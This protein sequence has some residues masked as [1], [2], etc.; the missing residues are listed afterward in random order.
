MRISPPVVSSAAQFLGFAVRRPSASRTAA[1]GEVG[2]LFCARAEHQAL[3]LARVGLLL[4]T[5]DGYGLDLFPVIRY[6]LPR[7]KGIGLLR[8][9]LF[10]HNIGAP[11]VPGGICVFAVFAERFPAFLLLRAGVLPFFSFS[12]AKPTAEPTPAFPLAVP[13]DIVEAVA[14]I[15]LFNI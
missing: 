8:P 14:L 4:G 12:V 11:F 7:F 2:R 3:G 9:F 15:A 10:F 1:P 6:E 13:S 5:L